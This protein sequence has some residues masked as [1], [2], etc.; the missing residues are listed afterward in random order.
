MCVCV[1]AC[2]RACVTPNFVPTTPKHS[3][4][5]V[6]SL[7]PFLPFNT[8]EDMHLC[9]CVC[10][11]VCVTPKTFKSCAN[12]EV[13]QPRLLHH[14]RNHDFTVLQCVCVR[15]PIANCPA[16]D[17]VTS[18]CGSSLMPMAIH[19]CAQQFWAVVSTFRYPAPP[20]YK[21]RQNPKLIRPLRLL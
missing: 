1:C 17:D 8:T 10:V 18:L 13:Q 11:C 3:L 16:A 20:L 7:R 15:A 14:L 5:Y 19:H 9:V 12:C 21:L 4:T 2:V 6:T